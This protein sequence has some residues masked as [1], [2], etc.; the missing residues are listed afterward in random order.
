MAD[1][2]VDNFLAKDGESVEETRIRL[3]EEQ[4]KR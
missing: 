1:K 3:A 4:K 2:F